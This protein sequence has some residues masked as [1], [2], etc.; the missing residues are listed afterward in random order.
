MNSK[1]GRYLRIAIP[2]ACMVALLLTSLMG[3]G[4]GKKTTTTEIKQED[5]T[6]LILATTTS[7][8]DTGLLDEWIPMFEAKNP[9]STKVVA[10]GSGAAIEMGRKGEADVLL[11]HSPADEEKLVADGYGTERAAVMHND[12][13]IV[14]PPSDPAGIKGMASVTDAFKKIADSKS[15]FISR[16]DKSGTNAKELAVWKAAGITPS[17]DWYIESGK[18]M[19]D[20]LKIANEKNAYTLSDRGT[21]LAQKGSLDLV[22]MVE[23]DKLLQNYY[24]VIVVNPEKYPGIN[25]DGARAFAAF[26]VSPEAQEFLNVFGVDKYGE[27]LFYPD[28]L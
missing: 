17:G 4:C 6:E 3:M 13:I 1:M 2:L 11:V 27:Q 24:H 21:Y 15:T 22:I 20:T 28:A 16:G 5:R 19:G 7:T 8:Q 9:Y 10:V 23:G 12:F 18:G 26:V 14:G 25:V